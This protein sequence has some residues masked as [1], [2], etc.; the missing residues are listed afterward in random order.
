LLDR[1]EQ[2]KLRSADQLPDLDG[3][4]LEFDWG[5][6]KGSDGEWS[7]IIRSGDVEVWRELAFFN[8]VPRFEQ[9]KGILKSKYGTR[10][11]SLTP[12]AASIEW[13]SGD[14]IGRALQVSYT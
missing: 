11:K 12:T 2:E 1:F 7:Q 4:S 13:L 6:A 9:I 10:F 3:E 14:D 5:F 8:N